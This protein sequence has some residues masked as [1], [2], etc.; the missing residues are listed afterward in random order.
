MRDP[1]ILHADDVAA[2]ALELFERTQRSAVAARGRFVVSLSG[3]ST[4]LP[5]YRALAA[6][7]DLPWRDTW[8]AWGD[9]RYVPPEHP[10]SNAGAAREAFLDAVPV[11]REQVLPWPHLA[12]PE[13]SASAYAATLRG[14][15]GDAPTFDL[16]LLGLGAD[17]HTAS[18]FP[19]TGAALEPALTL[20][21]RPPDQPRTRLSLGAAALSRSRVVAFLVRGEEKRAALRATLHG[22]G[23]LDRFPARAIGALER[24]LVITDLDDL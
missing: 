10:D 22:T 23:D 6:R 2:A 12:T 14:A 13:G 15:L 1:E 18:L 16:T 19:G 4:P 7:N 21:V 9:E 8:V 11:P 5:M 24:L 20:V 3:G 17:G